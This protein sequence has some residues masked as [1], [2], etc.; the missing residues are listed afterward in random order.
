M[1]LLER[2]TTLIGVPLA[3][4]LK[5]I[6]YAVWASEPGRAV[7]AA[8]ILALIV[9]RTSDPQVVALA[10]W[11]AGIA[12]LVE[13]AMEQA[14]DQLDAAAAG[15]A[16]LDQP[17]TVAATQ[18]SK[19]IPLAML[20]RYD[21][22]MACGR[23][24]RDVAQQHGDLKL[25]HKIEVNLGNIAFRRDRYSEAEAWYRS[26]LAF[27]EQ[28]DEPEFVVNLLTNLANV[29]AWR[30][31]LDAADGLY[32]RALQMARS[33]GLTVVEAGIAGNL[34]GLALF[35]GRYDEALDLLEQARRIYGRLELPQDTALTEVE[36]A[37]AY[38]ELNLAPEALALYE[39]ALPIFDQSGF[40]FEA[41]WARAHYGRA[42]L[43]LGRFDEARAALQ[44]AQ[45]AFK[46]E[47]NGL[48]GALVGV[49]EAQLAL[50]SGAFNEV[51][52]HVAKAEPL[53]RAA[54]NL[55]QLVAA[56][57]LRGEAFHALGRLDA[58]Q[59]V[60]E[61]ALHTAENGGLPQLAQI[62]HTALG[63]I[64]LAHKDIGRAA[65]EFQCAIELIESLRMP[66]PAEEFRT[67]FV[68]DKLVP[69]AEMARIC[70]DADTPQ[71]ADALAFVEQ[72]RSRALLE[73]LGSQVRY[74]AA[75]PR[76]AFESEQIQRLDQ[77]REELNW[78]YRQIN[79][80]LERA[81]PGAAMIA[82]LQA[83]AGERE[84]QILEM[85]RRIQQRG[86]DQLSTAAGLD[87]ARLQR[88]L[89][90]AAALVEYYS[91]DDELI[92]FVVTGA[93]VHV[94][95]DL[96][97]EDELARLVDQLRFQT[98][99]VRRGIGRN[100]AHLPQLTRRAQHYLGRLYD[101]LMRPIAGL[102]AE[103]RL[104]I[105]PHRMLHYVPFQALYDGAR[106]LIETHEIVTAPSAAIF[107]RCQNIPP[108][109]KQQALLL[110]VPD[111]RA[112]RVRDEILALA[113]LWPDRV[114]LLEDQATIAALQRHASAASV[115]HLACHGQF[116][117][118]S[119]LFSSLRLA[120]GWLTVRDAYKLELDC[121]LVVL[122]ACE[123]GVSTVAPGD[124]LLGL[125]RGFFAAGA[126]ALLVS[127]WTVDDATTAELMA[128]FYR[129][130]RAG[131][132]PATALRAA[133]SALL[134]DH[135]HPFFWAPF[136][137][138]GRW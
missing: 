19:L 91:L 92:A 55:G 75:R 137:L 69:F 77:V 39:R 43:V 129:R 109:G 96:A 73:M 8:A 90:S 4:T 138:M 56:Q 25:A 117:P 108:S 85:T 114:A 127:L 1:A 105:I 115:L 36:M 49:I 119:P 58:A 106:Y 24:A 34:G 60:F 18:V 42:C 59:M 102:L 116:R 130:L 7:A 86:G 71:A 53:L 133:Q 35:R 51:E 9:A 132:R 62:C 126:P 16:A 99:A 23:A 120:D 72:A 40:Q 81:D 14:I 37:D 54:G 29:L 124:E 100:A 82:Q 63:R 74:L 15:F 46:L 104:V 125:A 13:G 26:A 80:R 66:L 101:L 31:Q 103:R 57:T 78:L 22:A 17:L 67:A 21:E 27:F 98:D 30:Y 93:D 123:T 88:D 136:V 68:A 128:T 61:Q 33:A 47:E 107:Q 6:C 50:R 135:P 84:L 76:D 12:G 20:G 2:H 121:D 118:D 134:R 83:A 94:V 44:Q 3:A 112:P 28:A 41:A 95:R 65:A 32:R 113:P 38:L 52:T 5:D 70:L 64:A 11:T 89:D 111:A 45:A 87:L 10:A 110:G 97:G 131:D 122:S 79:R 48:W